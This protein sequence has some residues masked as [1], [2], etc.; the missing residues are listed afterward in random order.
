MLCVALCSQTSK[1][2]VLTSLFDQPLEHVSAYFGEQ[3][4]F[5]FA[6]FGFYTQWLVVPTIL[7]LILF[8]SQLA[9]TTIDGPLVPFYCL[10]MAVWATLCL[11]SW[12]RQNTR[13]AYDWGVLS[14]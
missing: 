7:G 8:A 2:S 5:Y 10:A 11:E 14:M 1:W 13:L 3:I 9:A 12:K 4:A 6:W